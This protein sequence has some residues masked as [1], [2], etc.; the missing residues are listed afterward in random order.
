MRGRTE[1]IHVVRQCLDAPVNH[2]NQGL[3][4]RSAFEFES[5]RYNLISKCDLICD[6][7]HRFFVADGS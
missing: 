4:I 7:F 5:S 3:A 6:H 2:R 1:A